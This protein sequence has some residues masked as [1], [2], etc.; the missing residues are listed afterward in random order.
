MLKDALNFIRLQVQDIEHYD[1]YSI[2][3]IIL[4]YVLLEA[5]SYLTD[6]LATVTL[7]EAL[8][9]LLMTISVF[10]FFIYWIFR[11][12]KKHSLTLACKFFGVMNIG[13]SIAIITLQIISVP[14]GFS[15]ENIYMASALLLFIIFITGITTSKAIDVSNTYSLIGATLSILLLI[16]F[17]SIYLMIE[18][19]LLNV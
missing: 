6:G 2:S 16:V 13:I 17:Y 9:N 12:V 19:M 3:S 4:I 15:L 14:L 11:K 18:M 7:G 10:L 5:L 1:K 8:G